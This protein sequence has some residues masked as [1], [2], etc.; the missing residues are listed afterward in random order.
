MG[1]Y[2]ANRQKRKILSGFSGFMLIL[3]AFIL[4]L[5]A[6]VWAKYISNR[7]MDAQVSAKAF[8]F[9]SDLLIG[10]SHTLPAG[11][12]TV[13]FTVKNHPDSLR[14]SEVDIEF[15]ATLLQGSDV[16]ATQSGTLEIA[17][18]AETVAFDISSL[19]AGTYW[20]QCSATAPYAKTLFATFTLLPTDPDISYSVADGAGNPVCYLTV[21]VGD[22]DGELSVAWPAGVLPDPQAPASATMTVTGHAEYQF[23]FFKTDISQVYSEAD[24][25][26]TRDSH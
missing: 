25:A 13:S 26:V 24:F 14:T 4:A 21:T 23:T 18:G 12:Q 7:Q 3:L 2:E 15:T 10:G 9:E 1:K 19:P 5:C 17:E 20:V 11:T 16:L 6:F 8:Y 22:Y